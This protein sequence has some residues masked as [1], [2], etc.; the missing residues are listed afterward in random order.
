MLKIISSVLILYALACVFLYL[1]QRSLLFFPMPE[2]NQADANAVWIKTG[3]ENLKLW[4]FNQGKPAILYFGGNSEAVEENI[5]S[6][7]TLFE[8]YTVYLVNYRGY[9]GSSGSPSEDGL[10]HDALAIYDQLVA[11][12][13]SISVIGRSL[14]SGVACYLAAH[15]NVDKLAL[16][17]PYDSIENVAQSHYFFFPVK[18][19]LKDK[20]DSISIAPALHNQTLVLM[21][22]HDQVIPLKHSHRLVQALTSA[23][24]ETQLISAASHNDILAHLAT[25]SLLTEFFRLSR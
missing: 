19:L 6:F 10:K 4:K 18:W 14:G 5:N 11:Q 25:Q 2:N 23:R 12:H 7:R 22:E 13:S 21:A 16:I 8:Q 15:R 17:T 3:E 24:L 20:F 9:A 1:K